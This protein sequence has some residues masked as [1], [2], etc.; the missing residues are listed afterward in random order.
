M[1]IRNLLDT[2]NLLVSCSEGKFVP[3]EKI[4]PRLWKG[5]GRKF[6]YIPRGKNEIKKQNKVDQFVFLYYI[7]LL[8]KE[9][10]TFI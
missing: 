9:T 3:N 5:S 6:R 1:H 2:E 7:Y 10:E 8:E 4:H